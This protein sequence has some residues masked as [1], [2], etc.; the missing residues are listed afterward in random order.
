MNTWCSKTPGNLE[1]FTSKLVALFVLVGPIRECS[2]KPNVCLVS[3]FKPKFMPSWHFGFK[4]VLSGIAPYR[5]CSG[6]PGVAHA[7]RH[8]CTSWDY[9]RFL[10]DHFGFSVPTCCFRVLLL[11]FFIWICSWI[12]IFGL[13]YFH[14][15]DS[16]SDTTHEA[17]L[18]NV[19][20]R[21]RRL[22]QQ[23][24]AIQSS[25]ATLQQQ[26]TIIQQ[27][28]QLLLHIHGHSDSKP[29]VASPRTSTPR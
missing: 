23:V 17:I 24:Q 29:T 6:G 5:F 10:I 19:V 15:S 11:Q 7:P 16:S 18:H 21:Q 25:V 3:F 14:M 28:L 1:M 22:E 12:F 26:L 20:S 2:C 27:Q 13:A 9:R 4:R 8:T